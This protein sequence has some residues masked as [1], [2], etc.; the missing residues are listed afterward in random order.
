L[1][2]TRGNRWQ[3]FMFTRQIIKT[4]L[5]HISPEHPYRML[6]IGASGGLQDRWK[7]L[8]DVLKFV[9]VEPNPDAA[10]ELRKEYLDKALI[11]ERLLGS[12]AGTAQLHLTRDPAC[13][14]L[15]APNTSLLSVWDN[16]A[17]FDVLDTMSLQ[18]S[19][20]D[21]ELQTAGSPGIDFI[22]IDTQGS[23]LDILMG[24][25]ETLKQGVC[26]LEIEVEFV[27]MYKGQPLFRDVDSW[28]G[29]QGFE[30]V[31]LNRHFWR[32]TCGGKG[33]WRGQLVWADALYLRSESSLTSLLE[34][35][36]DPASRIAAL[37]NMVVTT[38]MYG[39]PD[40]AFTHVLTTE[41]AKLADVLELR[42]ILSSGEFNQGQLP[43][44]RGE[45]RLARLLR[46]ILRMLETRHYNSDDDGLGNSR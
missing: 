20:L 44:F 25:N 15:F 1:R 30:L 21:D 32:R 26:G 23:E 24:G 14:S 37:R 11:I 7:S 42:K 3:H 45:T 43:H 36:D 27:E 5:Q 17:R 29:D 28:L 46:R 38:L 22:K 2:A 33:S 34:S 31:D 39:Y 18:M 13:S 4:L 6:D 40:I 16:P 35:L 8:R 10:A 19:R 9:L 12:Q 41:N